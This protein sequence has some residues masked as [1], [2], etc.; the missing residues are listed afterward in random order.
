M[1]LVKVTSCPRI[2]CP[3]F[4]NNIWLTWITYVHLLVKYLRRREI[5]VRLVQTW[6]LRIRLWCCGSATWK[7]KMNRDWFPAFSQDSSL[8]FYLPSWSTT[9]FP[10][11]SSIWGRRNGWRTVKRWVATI[12]EQG[13][14]SH[15][16]LFCNVTHNY[17]ILMLLSEIPPI[18]TAVATMRSFLFFIFILAYWLM[19]I[20]LH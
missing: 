13:W 8:L 9:Q 7:E 10:K 4:F 1:K 3:V 2:A 18:I 20:R 6:P 14:H 5:P 15:A 11:V 16:V 17:P 12:S 19:K